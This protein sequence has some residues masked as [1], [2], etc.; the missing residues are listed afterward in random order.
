MA[1]LAEAHEAARVL[2]LKSKYYGLV[3]AP[4][5]YHKPMTE[6]DLEYDRCVNS[7]ILA[8]TMPKMREE[9][10]AY[11]KEHFPRLRYLLL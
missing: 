2:E 6:L 8:V 5:G 7:C 11:L 10:L 9:H 3:F 4:T 1:R